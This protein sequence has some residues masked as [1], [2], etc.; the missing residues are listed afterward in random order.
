MPK[1]HLQLKGLKPK[2]ILARLLLAF[3]LVFGCVYAHPVPALADVRA[4]D[5]VANKPLG[6]NHTQVPDAPD[7]VAD[8]AALCTKDGTILWE[9]NGTAQTYMASTT[10]IM[11]AMVALDTS[12]PDTPMYVTNGAANMEGSSASLEVGDTLPLKDLITCMMVPSGNDAAVAIA[13]NI[14]GTEFAFVDMM[15][16]KAAQLGMTGTHFS[17]ASGV[18]DDGN[19]TTA[20]DYLKLTRYAMSNDLFRQAVSQSE[21]TVDIDG[22]EVDYES[23]NQLLTTMD[24]VNGV[25]TGFTD[26]A[27]Y[28]VVA[29]AQRNDFELYAV[30]FHSSDENQRFVDAQTILEWGFAHYRPVQLIDDTT[31]V[32]NLSCISW[33]DTTVPVVA[34]SPVSVDV[35]DYQGPITQEVTLTEKAGA[36]SKGDV[37]GSVVWTQ[38]QEV[39][40]QVNLVAA[41]DVAAPGF[42][43]GV[44]IWWKR[45]WYNFTGAPKQATSTT[46]LPSTFDLKIANVDDQQ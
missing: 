40:A 43:E 24:G 2:G 7:V 18:T 33:I 14:A 39:L 45:L 13:E 25:K 6:E 28:C 34:Q 35:F 32:A 8:Y 23:T 15:N 19:Y 22:R 1:T 37:V 17:N 9:R 30:V 16:A 46:I 27:G 44:G 4:S 10:K 20:E 12:S 42:W 21:A 29:S 31:T 5:L 41:D 26:A 38:N 11:T 36:I 3:V